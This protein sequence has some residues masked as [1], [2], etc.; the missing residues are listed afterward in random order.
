M[1]RTK[2][3][4]KSRRRYL[5]KATRRHGGQLTPLTDISTNSSIHDLDDYDEPSNNTTSESIMSNATTPPMANGSVA[6]N[7]LGQ[8]NAAGDDESVNLTN[9]TT[10]ASDESSDNSFSD[11]ATSFGD[12]GH[13][14]KRRKEKRMKGGKKT[15]K[16]FKGMKKRS[17]RGGVRTWAQL[18]QE[19]EHRVYARLPEEEQSHYS[20]ECF[21][22]KNGSA[23]IGD[24]KIR[25]IQEA[26]RARIDTASR[27]MQEIARD[28]NARIRQDEYDSLPQQEKQNWVASGTEGPPWGQTT[29]YRRRQPSDDLNLRATNTPNIHLD[30]RQYAALDAA[31]KALGWVRVVESNYRESNVYYRRRV[32]ADNELDQV[33]ATIQKITA[34]CDQILAAVKPVVTGRMLDDASI[35]QLSIRTDKDAYVTLPRD[36]YNRYMVLS[37]MLEDEEAKKNRLERELGRL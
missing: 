35:P 25:R 10:A 7:L 16:I 21:H 6:T 18:P 29:I 30:E 9:N 26:Q 28:P 33:K 31:T 1:T 22:K 2:K 8:F 15:S 19:V 37:H 3:S 12:L 14:G 32:A 24:Q 4:F 11:V 5:K 13:G 20:D 34:E 17:M 27:R 36:R 23:S